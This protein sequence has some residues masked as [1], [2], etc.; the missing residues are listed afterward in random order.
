M[1]RNDN[2]GREY[3]RVVE[4]LEVL[5]G[6]RGAAGKPRAAVRRGEFAALAELQ[7]RQVAAAPTQAEFN[8]LQADLAALHAA[9]TRI[10]K[11]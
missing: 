11:A 4:R 10:G 1:A 7:S 2:V 3:G 5:T 6:E 9:L 8:A